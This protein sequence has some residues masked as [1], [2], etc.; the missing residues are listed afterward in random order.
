MEYT[1]KERDAFNRAWSAIC[2][3]S[4]AVDWSTM[5]DLEDALKYERKQRSS[6]V[7]AKALLA[8]SW[9]EGF[10]QPDTPAKRVAFLSKGCGRA[11]L[12]GAK[13]GDRFAENL[14]PE[15]RTAI[16]YAAELRNAAIHREMEK[17]RNM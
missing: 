13:V 9:L 14:Q 12:V 15:H 8:E 6:A 2:A 17:L 11:L 10:N 16:E 1:R 3:A 7:V 5:H 4:E